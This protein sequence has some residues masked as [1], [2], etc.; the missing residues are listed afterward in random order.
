MAKVTR[1]Y[2]GPDNKTHFEDLEIP[3]AENVRNGTRSEPFNVTGMLM[4][5][6]NG[7]AHFLEMHPAPRMPSASEWRGCRQAGEVRGGVHDNCLSFDIDL[8]TLT[9]PSPSKGEGSN[10]P[11]QGGGSRVRSVT[12]AGLPFCAHAVD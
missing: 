8:P 11:S 4:R 12:P 10:L 3:A 6:S 1:F 9:Q 5:E 2:T 7:D